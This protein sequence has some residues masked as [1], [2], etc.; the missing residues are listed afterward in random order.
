MSIF[1]PTVLAVA[2]LAVPEAQTP[3]E[4]TTFFIVRHAEKN[5]EQQLSVEGKKRAEDLKKFLSNQN[6]AAVYSTDYPRTMD[7]AK[8]TAAQAK[9]KVQ[10]YSPRARKE[11][12]DE[13]KK[14]H[15]GKSVLIVGHSN[16][17]VPT[18][19]GLGGSMK[20]KVGEDDYHNLF[21]VSV[22]GT[23]SQAVRINYGN[24]PAKKPVA[25]GAR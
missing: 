18:V 15:P 8:P 20:Y 22:D 4:P 1:V 14:K 17:V 21:I 2:F 10:T 6:I 19:N 12:F 11:W 5:A 25:S 7:T 16:T 23:K 24:V 3:P 9:V 13:L